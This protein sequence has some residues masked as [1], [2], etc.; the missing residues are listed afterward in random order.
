VARSQEMCAASVAVSQPDD[1]RDEGL[2][3]ARFYFPPGINGF[4]RLM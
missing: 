4:R 2:V 1:G 3:V